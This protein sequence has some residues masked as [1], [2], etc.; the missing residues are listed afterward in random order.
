M[1]STFAWCILHSLGVVSSCATPYLHSYVALQD[2][3]LLEYGPRHHIISE[4][5]LMTFTGPYGLPLIAI[6]DGNTKVPVAHMFFVG[7]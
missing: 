5:S 4:L 2:I 7:L 6:S 3:Q 1:K